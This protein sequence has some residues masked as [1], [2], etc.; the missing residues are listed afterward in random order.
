[1]KLRLARDGFPSS[2]ELGARLRGAGE[3]GASRGEGEEGPAEYDEDGLLYGY[4]DEDWLCECG[5]E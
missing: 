4:D 1:M 3:R 2:D 5:A